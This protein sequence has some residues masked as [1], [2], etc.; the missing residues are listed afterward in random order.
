MITR[1]S[2]NLQ[3]GKAGEHLVC[4][5]LLMKGHNA[6][7]ADQGLPFDVLIE[8]DGKIIRMQVKTISQINSYGLSKNIYRFTTRR[9]NIKNNRAIEI[10]EVDHYAFVVAPLKIIAYISVKNLKSKNTGKINQ[11]VE[12]KTRSLKYK[13][14]PFHKKIHGKFI[15]DFSVFKP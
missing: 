3:I 2:K 8:K 10:G 6:F 12:F 4:F 15:E 7:L 11:L 13:L 14:H 5:D 1:L 9:G